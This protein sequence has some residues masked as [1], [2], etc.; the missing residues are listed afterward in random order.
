MLDYGDGMCVFFH[1]L[2]ILGVLRAKHHEEISYTPNDTGEKKK[3]Q[4]LGRSHN[5][6]NHNCKQGSGPKVFNARRH[7]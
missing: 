3:V 6:C 1:S 7:M 2:A 5:V 4:L